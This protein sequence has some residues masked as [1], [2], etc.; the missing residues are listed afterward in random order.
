MQAMSLPET[1]GA[2]MDVASKLKSDQGSNE[3]GDD[4]LSS[5][6]T[7]DDLSNTRFTFAG[8]PG[9]T[10]RLKWILISQI[11]RKREAQVQGRVPRKIEPS[12]PEES[13]QFF[14]A[15]TGNGRFPV[16]LTHA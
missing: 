7:R 9:V 8:T 4:S 10:S 5:V 15:W 16:K 3:R 2:H 14:V 12:P 13:I 6:R 1:F 11:G